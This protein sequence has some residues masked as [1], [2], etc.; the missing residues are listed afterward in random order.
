MSLPKEGEPLQLADGSLL[1][2]DGS[3][4]K[5]STQ[6]EY[7][8]VPTNQQAV[9]Q[10]TAVRRRVA[11]LPEVP[12]KMNAVS[13]VLAYHLFGLSDRDIGIATN[14][15]EQQVSNIRMTSAFSSMMEAVVE[16]IQ[17]QGIDD[18]RAL[19]A[20]KAKNAAT[21]VSDLLNAEAEAVQLQAA[22]DILDRAG[23]RPADVVEHRHKMEGGLHIVVEK[24]DRTQEVP[25]FTFDGEVIDDANG[26]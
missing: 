2:P 21:K 23:H 3:I 24:R 18:V 19:L 17:K 5:P 26:S 8:E 9:Q 15:S 22:K 11:E 25:G 13:V 12:E 16:S 6:E 1:M 20:Q 14:L 10:I 7:V 4:K